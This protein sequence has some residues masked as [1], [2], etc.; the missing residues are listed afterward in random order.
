MRR[1]SLLS[2]LGALV[3]GC[4]A[5]APR[6]AMADG[7]PGVSHHIKTVF[8]ILMENHNWTGDDKSIEGKKRAHYIDNVLVPMGSHAEQYYNPP[9]LHPSLPNYLWLEAGTNFGI[10]HDGLPKKNGQDTTQHLVTLLNNE[11]VTWKAYLEDAKGGVCPLRNM[12]P[13][14]ANGSPSFAVRHEPFS[15]FHDVT[16]NFNRQSQYCIDHLRP[17]GELAKDLQ[18]N[19][20]AQYN[21]ITPN[22]CNDMH[23]N[24]DHGAVRNGDQWLADVVPT[25]M[26]SKAYQDGGAIFIT[27]D[28]ANTGDGPIPMIV[29]SPFAKGHGYSNDIAYTHGST[30]R[31]MEEIFGVTPLLGDAANQQDLSDLFSVFP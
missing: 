30:L 16:D 29:L 13:V 3:L 18:R 5:L 27:F 10:L 28:E 25:I 11:G 19:T 14:D 22:L 12:G 2:V 21:W 6:A 7:K 4:L 31:T 17:F 26:N 24:C 9:G 20:V 8:I 15:Y 1:L 23:D